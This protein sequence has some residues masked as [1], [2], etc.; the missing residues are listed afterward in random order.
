MERGGVDGD[1]P[2]GEIDAVPP[3]SG[4]RSGPHARR[5]DN[6]RP[7]LGPAAP[8]S[9]ARWRSG[10]S[11]SPGPRARRSSGRR[12]ARPR[13]ATSRW[14]RARSGSRPGPRA[15]RRRRGPGPPRAR[16][17]RSRSRRTRRTASAPVHTGATPSASASPGRSSATG[18]VAG[19][20]I[21]YVASPV[22]RTVR[23]PLRVSN[24]A[25]SPSAS[26]PV[27]YKRCALANVAC[28]HRSTSVVGVSQR[29][30]NVPSAPGVTKAVSAR[31]IS[32][33]SAR[34]QSSP[35]GWRRTQT[36]GGVAG[37]RPVREGV[38][39]GDGHGRAVACC[40]LRIPARSRRTR[41]TQHA[42]RLIG[43]T[44][45]GGSGRRR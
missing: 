17:L 33:A 20:S 6:R 40:V 25:G 19:K 21:V 36:A 38:D 42:L 35:T 28:P 10:R 13:R 29:R 34:I 11:R 4:R 7:H 8:P 27:S 39:D 24:R 3:A 44:P 14:R 15:R 31:F 26:S 23:R 22:L 2:A 37:E 45:R 30:P 32:T 5:L 12:S 16:P 9:T 41:N 18:G 1:G 43:G